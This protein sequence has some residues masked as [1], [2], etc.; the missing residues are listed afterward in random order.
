MFE[1]D[2]YGQCTKP[3]YTRN[4]MAFY[5]SRGKNSLI[6]ASKTLIV[7]FRTSLH[8]LIRGCKLVRFCFAIGV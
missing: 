3:P 1:L 4:R 8:L 6:N 2:E 7:C 5:M